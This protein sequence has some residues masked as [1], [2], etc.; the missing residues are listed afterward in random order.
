MV[1][2]H[3]SYHYFLCIILALCAANAADTRAQSALIDGVQKKISVFDRFGKL[4]LTSPVQIG[5]GGVGVK[6]SMAD[7]IT[8]VGEFDVD[9]I[10]SHREDEVAVVQTL[11]DRFGRSPSYRRYFERRSGLVSL[12]QSM[13]SL[14]FDGNKEPDSAYG[15]GYIGLNSKQFVTGPKMHQF[16][17]R[18]YWFS[19][20]LHGT[21]DEDGFGKGTSG[22][23][24]HLPREV[25]DR[26][27]TEE[28]LTLGSKVTISKSGK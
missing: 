2:P 12:F 8:P 23:C 7:F 18:P 19:I 10:L 21:P 1:S 13:N 5:K 17:G 4:M 3:R 28:L 27:L 15:R 22:G 11:S 9:I 20:A 26:I 24:V 14:D 16:K 6:R 25:L